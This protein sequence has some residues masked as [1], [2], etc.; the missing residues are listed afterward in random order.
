MYVYYKIFFVDPV[1]TGHCTENDDYF[2]DFIINND[3]LFILN[4]NFFFFDYFVMI[5]IVF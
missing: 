3:A 4:P 5:S 1:K 2:C